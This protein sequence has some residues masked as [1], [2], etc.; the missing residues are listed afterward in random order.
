MRRWLSA[1]AFL[2]A[3][4][5]RA[6]LPPTETVD[7]GEVRV[8]IYTWAFLSEAE[9][10]ALRLAQADAGAL[11]RLV[12]AAK[13]FAAVAVSPDEAFLQDGALIAPGQAVSGL[14]TLEAAWMAAYEACNALRTG[15]T[16][17]TIV[18]EIAPK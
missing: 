14:P 4:A 3:G 7:L 9:L 2:A 12:P 17:C 18:L 15:E 11:A 6:D 16:D 5:A 1:L 13:G 8:T 10:S